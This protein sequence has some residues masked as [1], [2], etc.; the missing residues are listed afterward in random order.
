MLNS[1][2]DRYIFTNGLQYIQ[3]NFFL[4]NMPFAIIP[5]DIFAGIAENED[6]ELNIKLYRAVRE[7]VRKSVREDFQID[8]GISGEKGLD[9]MQAYF[10]ASGWG[11]IE[12]TDLNREKA[13]ALVTVTN[14]PVAKSCRKAKAPVDTFLRGIL[15][16]IFSIYFKKDVDCVETAC[17]AL[18]ANHCTF[19]IKPLAEFDFEKRIT[20]EQLRVE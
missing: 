11:K 20:R 17:A 4:L 14:S 6:R 7:S 13:H 2:Y 10:S 9:F 16:G 5:V 12:R 3:D 8:F 18:H 1:F 19:V 15:A